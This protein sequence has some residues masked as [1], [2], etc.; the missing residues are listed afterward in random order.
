MQEVK[1]INQLKGNRVE[2]F[3]AEW[4]GACKH[5]YSDMNEMANKN[6]SVKFFKIDVDKH[7]EYAENNGI[8]S[9]P[10]IKFYNV[11][12]VNTGNIVGAKLSEIKSELQKIL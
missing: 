1:N 11:L 5:I 8:S 12:E 9:I 7:Q 10:F 4:C 6:K 3:T 2:Y